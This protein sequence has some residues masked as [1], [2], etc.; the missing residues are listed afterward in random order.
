MKRIKVKI[1]FSAE[2]GN[3]VKFCVCYD[4]MVNERFYTFF[5]DEEKTKVISIPKEKIKYV[6]DVIDWE[7]E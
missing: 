5:L 6:E 3:D 2:E 7:E 1:V 4:W